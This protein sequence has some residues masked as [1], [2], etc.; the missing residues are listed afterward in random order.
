MNDQESDSGFLSVF[1]VDKFYYSYGESG[2]HEAGIGPQQHADDD[3][4]YYNNTNPVEEI[5]H[6]FQ[7]QLSITGESRA[8]YIEGCYHGQQ[9]PSDDGV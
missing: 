3:T 4:V 8:Y 9:F 2:Q 1:D 5:S 7:N 6:A